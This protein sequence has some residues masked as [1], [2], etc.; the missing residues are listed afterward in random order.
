MSS[1][2]EGRS[3]SWLMRARE[4]SGQELLTSGTLGGRFAGGFGGGDLALQIPRIC[5]KVGQMT[6]V[7]QVEELGLRQAQ[8]LGGLTR[9]DLALLKKLKEH[10]LS[11]LPTQLRLRDIESR[12]QLFG[13]LDLNL[14]HSHR[15]SLLQVVPPVRACQT[16]HDMLSTCAASIPPGLV[17]RLSTTWCLPWS[18][19]L[20]PARP[21]S[22][23]TISSSMRPANR[24]RPR[25]CARWR[26]R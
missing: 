7:Q 18:A 14:Q 11:G 24:E 17:T 3:P 8:K 2:K 26:G 4:I 25:P 19:C 22:A 9:R 6:L 23:A 13:K 20:R 12:K 5:I 21:W 10:P 15:R 1:N 16:K